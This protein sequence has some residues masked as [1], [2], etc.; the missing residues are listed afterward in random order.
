MIQIKYMH[1]MKRSF[2]DN[3]LVQ[4]YPFHRNR[5]TLVNPSYRVHNKRLARMDL[6][7]LCGLSIV[8]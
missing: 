5:V 1:M 7:L 6:S 4:H 2:L 3:S 8:Q